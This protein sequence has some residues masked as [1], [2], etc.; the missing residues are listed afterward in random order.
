MCGRWD[1]RRCRTFSQ[2]WCRKVDTSCCSCSWLALSCVL[3][4]LAASSALAVLPV[5][6]ASAAFACNQTHNPPYSP[7]QQTLRG[8][9]RP[10]LPAQ[11]TPQTTTRG[12]A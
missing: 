2:K 7:L 5:S 4:W 3:A 6:S 1:E 9:F 8:A 12:L 10:V 11:P